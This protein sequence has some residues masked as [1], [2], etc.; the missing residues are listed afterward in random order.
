MIFVIL[1]V[2]T[3]VLLLIIPLFILYNT[4]EIK[5]SVKEIEQLREK[6]LSLY[7]KI[8]K[9]NDEIKEN[10]DEEITKP[11][12]IKKKKNHTQKLEGGFMNKYE[13]KLESLSKY[14]GDSYKLSLDYG[15]KG[16]INLVI[17]Y[18]EKVYTIKFNSR[19][20]NEMPNSTIVKKIKNE[21]NKNDGNKTV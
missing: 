19:K 16:Y 17:H 18:S 13:N 9:N 14:L 5:K 21:I 3:F 11:E 15:K 1:C 12:H 20:F 10:K 7:D 6:N 8:S 2:V 4:R